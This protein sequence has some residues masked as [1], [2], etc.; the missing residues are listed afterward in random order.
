MQY[1]L[2]YAID[3]L[4]RPEIQEYL[5]KSTLSKNLIVALPTETL[6]EVLRKEVE[7]GTIN[8]TY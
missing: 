4:S 3:T 6:R 8:V 1:Q 2:D 7:R 5:E